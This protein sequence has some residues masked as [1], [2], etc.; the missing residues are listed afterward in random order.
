MESNQTQS[1]KNYFSSSNA[2]GDFEL[3]VASPW[4]AFTT[5]YSGSVPTTI[6]LTSAQTT[7][8]T[9][10]V[11]PLS[12]TTSGQFSKSAANAVGQG[13]ISSVLTI[14]RT[15]LA[16]V[17][18]GQF[19]YEPISGTIDFSGS[20]TSSF[21]IW[22]YNVTAGTWIQPSG[23]RGLT[24]GSGPSKVSY[25]FQTDSTSANNQYRIAIIL[26][27]T[28][29]N[30]M[31]VNFD[32]FQLGPQTLTTG[33]AGDDFVP[34]TPSFNG[35]GTPS[36][37][38]FKSR[39]VGDCLHVLGYVT[40]GT[41]TA[42]TVQIALGYKGVSGNVTIDPTK[43][44]GSPGYIVGAAA[45]TYTNAG[46]FG[47]DVL[48]FGGN[49]FVYLGAQT[50]TASQSG[51]NTATGSNFPVGATVTVEFMVPIQGWSSNV[52]QSSDSDQRIIAAKVNLTTNVSLT[53]GPEVILKFNSIE[54]DTSGS[55]D[56]TTG[57]Y[58]VK[59]SG[60]FDVSAAAYLTAPPAAV[61]QGLLLYKNGALYAQL[62]QIIGAA[63]STSWLGNGSVQD[64]KCNAGDTLAIYAFQ[65]SGSTQTLLGSSIN[66]YACF[67][68]KS[69][70]AVVQATESVNASYAVT[71]APSVA[72]GGNIKY[73]SRLKDT[74]AAYNTT[75][76]VYT[77]PVSGEYRLSIT[78]T[79][80]SV[81]S[82]YIIKNS[83]GFGYLATSPSNGFV[84]SASR[85]IPLLAGD[86]I[87]IAMDAAATLAAPAAQGAFNTFSIERVGN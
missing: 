12:G 5:V 64:V 41:P 15:D 7:L 9:V 35:F 6:T 82:A 17:L 57:L 45:Q 55:Y 31:V 86:T 52:Q 85:G 16:K 56:T 34:F 74:H 59:S 30:A 26:P 25:S 69:G 20:S 42:V 36:A 49:P 80:T 75:S 68:K 67:S 62:S 37:V 27:Q 79:F 29:T 38:S 83:V 71:G 23:Y 14:D 1:R 60:I 47:L 87:S 10:S 19:S 2:N 21:E 51:V 63:S 18:F 61:N 44:P 81:S 53:N 78:A 40:I 13:F 39:R 33:F 77:V 65:N 11:T 54:T 8:T 22:I 70:S 3:G 4:S 66:T 50:S 58:T 73:D 76:G 32:E 46:Y 43:V 48:A 84:F 72:A 24:Q 28:D